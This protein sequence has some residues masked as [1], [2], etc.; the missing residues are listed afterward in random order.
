M[1]SGYDAM[2]LRGPSLSM[3]ANVRQGVKVAQK[4]GHWSLCTLSMQKG[5]CEIRPKSVVILNVWPLKG[6]YPFGISIATSTK[7][8]GSIKLLARSGRYFKAARLGQCLTLLSFNIEPTIA[9]TF[10]ANYFNQ[11]VFFSN[12]V[13]LKLIKVLCPQ[14]K[15]AITFPSLEK[16][17]DSGMKHSST[18]QVSAK[19]F[20][21]DL[22]RKV[23]LYFPQPET[24]LF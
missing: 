8:Y 13:P 18:I 22:S 14:H 24:D 11:L 12:F 17:V 23:Y 10:L 9:I 15:L 16:M 20:Y 19:K 7:N 4:C 5:G 1:A 3:T 6:I 2:H 21:N